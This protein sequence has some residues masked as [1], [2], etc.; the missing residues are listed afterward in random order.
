MWR[1]VSTVLF[2]GQNVKMDAKGV[3]NMYSILVLQ[4]CCT[5]FGRPLRPSSH[6]GHGIVQCSPTSTSIQDLF[7][8]NSWQT[9]VAAVAVYSAP[10]DGRKGRPKHVELK[11]INQL[12]RISCISLVFYKTSIYS[13]LIVSQNTPN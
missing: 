1:S 6:F 10:E 2:H 8:P 11:K 13:L 5:C 9:P 7:Q 4:V 3:R 12:N